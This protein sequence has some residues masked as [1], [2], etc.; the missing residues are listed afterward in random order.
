MGETQADRAGAA[1]GGGAGAAGDRVKS[2]R[3]LLEEKLAGMKSE[4]P[5]AEAA[6]KAAAERAPSQGGA[7]GPADAR[8]GTERRIAE[9]EKERDALRSE[10]LLARADLDNYQ[11]R[12]RREMDEVRAYAAQAVLADLL[13]ALDNIDFSLAAAKV[14]PDLDQL[15]LGVEM[16]R[17]QIEKVLADRGATRIPAEGVPFDPRRHEAIIAEERADL[18]DMTV[19]QELRRGYAL[20]DRVI[21]AAQ[22]KVARRPSPGA[23]AADAP[24]PARE[25]GAKGH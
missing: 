14:K 11:K 13:T 24:D 19:V 2:A 8:S 21:R 4:A 7:A 20:R 23:G 9:L 12:I 6:L 15:V 22:V 16:V 25:A 1:E 10:A 18:P 3:E 5:A 17:A